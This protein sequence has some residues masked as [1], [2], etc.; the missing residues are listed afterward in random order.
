MHWHVWLTCPTYAAMSQIMFGAYYK[1]GDPTRCSGQQVVY[2][3]K[4]CGVVKRCDITATTNWLGAGTYC[5]LDEFKNGKL[6]GVWWETPWDC[7]TYT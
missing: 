5:T 2:K 1:C 6:E 4:D 7:A 3:T